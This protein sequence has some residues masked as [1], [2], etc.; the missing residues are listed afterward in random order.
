MNPSDVD[1]PGYLEI[2]SF[3]DMMCKY[4]GSD[5]WHAVSFSKIAARVKLVCISVRVYLCFFNLANREIV[6]GG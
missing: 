2:V 3:D 1:I 6:C 5:D 4:R